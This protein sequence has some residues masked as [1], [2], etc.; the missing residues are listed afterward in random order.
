M[1]FAV[2]LEVVIGAK[3]KNRIVIFLSSLSY[4]MV[5]PN[6]NVKLKYAMDS[7]KGKRSIDDGWNLVFGV[8]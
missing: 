8:F 5:F 3:Q 4:G 6:C 1:D 2:V 7:F